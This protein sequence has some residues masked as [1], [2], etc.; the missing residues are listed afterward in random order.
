MARGVCMG[1]GAGGRPSWSPRP[2]GSEMLLAWIQRLSD[3]K[4]PESP[5]RNPEDSGQEAYPRLPVLV[6][7]L[8]VRSDGFQSLLR[9]HRQ[10]I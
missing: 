2:W 4:E 9:A 10:R 6:L 7:L 1:R 8:Q 5:A 3:S